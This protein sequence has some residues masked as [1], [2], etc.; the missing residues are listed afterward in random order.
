[1]QSPLGLLAGWW[2]GLISLPVFQFLLFRWYYRLV[3]WA[4]FLWQVSRIKLNLLATHPD[5]HGGLGF[6]TVVNYAFAPLLLAQGVLLSGMIAT[7]LLYTGARLADFK[8]DVLGLVAAVVFV[9]LAP[10]L[11]FCPQLIEVKLRGRREYGALAQHTS[12]TSPMKIK[13]INESTG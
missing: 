8:V 6:V 3:I 9:I 11:V 2:L 7:R 12:A 5:R 4:R 13:V 1:V 10:L